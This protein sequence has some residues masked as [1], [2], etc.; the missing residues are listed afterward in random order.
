MP[1]TAYAF[2][3]APNTT[4]FVAGSLIA[5]GLPLMSAPAAVGVTD[6]ASSARSDTAGSGS[7]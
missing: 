1:R 4:T 3:A 6:A 7:C 2:D 5:G